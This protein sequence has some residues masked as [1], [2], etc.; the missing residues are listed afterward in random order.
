MRIHSLSA[1]SGDDSRVQEDGRSEPRARGLINCTCLTDSAVDSTRRSL[2]VSTEDCTLCNNLKGTR[3]VPSLTLQTFAYT[4]SFHNLYAKRTFLSVANFDWW[5]CCIFTELW[6][7]TTEM[8]QKKTERFV[9]VA[10]TAYRALG[11]FKFHPLCFNLHKIIL[12]TFI[13]WEFLFPILYSVFIHI[14]H[15]LSYKSWN[16]KWARNR[17]WYLNVKGGL[18]QRWII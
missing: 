5:F 6:V 9:E 4:N 11:K 10:T 15:L 3:T 16:R 2:P 12:T 17:F 1:V 13:Q 8:A 7:I 14:W 18:H